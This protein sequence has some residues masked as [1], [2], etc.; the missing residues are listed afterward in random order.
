[1]PMKHIHRPWDAPDAILR[2]AGVVLGQTYPRP[3]VD[4]AWARERF[5]SVAREHLSTARS[6]TVA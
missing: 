1:M 3:I 2:A 4:H 6:E 5:L